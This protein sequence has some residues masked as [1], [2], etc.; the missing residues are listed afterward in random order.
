MLAYVGLSC[1][2]CGPILWLCWPMLMHVEPKDPKNGN[3]KKNTVKRRIFWWS[4]PLGLCWPILGL[5]GPIL[6]LCWSI[7]GLSWPIL[8][9]MLA[10]LGAMLAHLGPSWGPCWPILGAML[11]HLEPYVGP[12][13]PILS[14]KSRKSSKNGKSKIHCKTQGIL[15]V[16]GGGGWGRRQGA[17]PLSPTERRETL[18]A[19]TRPGGPWPDFDGGGRS[20]AGAAAPLSFGEERREGLRQC[21]GQG[22]MLRWY[23]SSWEQDLKAML[24]HLEAMFGRSWG[25]CWPHVD[26]CWAERAEKWEQQKKHCKTQD[27][28]MIGGLSWGYVGPSWGYVG[29]SWGQCGPILGLLVSS[30]SW[31]SACTAP[32]DRARGQQPRVPN[33]T[34]W[35]E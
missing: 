35:S 3:S 32:G 13:W 21:H 33:V 8:G 30:C 25:L 15:M 31:L 26:P 9:A 4:A 5:C 29:L 12:C 20:A 11:A 23:G 18:S 6:G 2:Q 19:R 14:H 24:P 34:F 10:D 22:P 1:G 16:R 7:L 27:S 28:L 17:R